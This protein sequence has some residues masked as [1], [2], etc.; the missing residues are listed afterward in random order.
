M[1][2][3]RGSWALVVLATALLCRAGVASEAGRLLVSSRDTAA[4]LGYAA[5]TGASEGAFIASG[6]GGLDETYGMLLGPD[7][8]L[9]VVGS[10]SNSVLRF[11]PET[12]AF[13]D[14]FVASGSGGL[15]GA[16]FSA[17]GPDGDLYVTSHFGHSVL[18]YDG[19]TGAFVSTFIPPGTGGLDSPGGL[20]FGPDGN[21]YLSDSY[22]NR[23]LRFDGRTGTFLDVFAAGELT[24]SSSL[25]F[26]P[27]GNLYVGSFNGNAVVRFDGRTGE[28]IDTFVT[29]GSGGLSGAVD[30]AFGPGGDLFVTSTN[31]D[32]VLRYDGTTGAF[33]SV[34]VQANSGGLDTPTGMAFLLPNGPPIARAG[35]DQE[36]TVAHDGKPDTGIAAVTLSGSASSDPDGDALAYQWEDENRE[37]VGS[38]VDLQL[39][40]PAG[41]FRYTL[42]VTDP[43]G[44]TSTD[45]VSVSVLPEPNQ[46]P[47]AKAGADQTVSPPHDGD[48]STSSVDVHLDGG[49]STDPDGDGLSYEWRDAEGEV[50]GR[51]AAI[52]LELNGGAHVLTLRVTDPYGAA[53]EDQVTVTVT[54]ELDE[55][56]TAYAGPDQ[57]VSIPHDGSPNTNL[58]EVTLA[59]DASFDLDGDPLAF[60]WEDPDGNVVGTSA[61]LPLTLPAGEYRYT[62]RVTDPYGA[63][64][65]DV[66]V[67]TVIPEANR[68][69]TASAGSDQSLT[70]PHD[71]D[72]GTRTAAVHLDGSSATDR[73]GDAITFE[74]RS[75]AG[76]VLAATAHL[77][78]TLEPGVHAFTLRVTDAYGIT[79]EDGVTVTVQPE[80][81]APPAANAG[82]DQTIRARRLPAKVRLDGNGSR[83]PDGDA[84]R[85]VW[86][87]KGHRVATGSQPRLQL[88]AG[89]HRIKLTV[90]DPYG[91]Q[92]SDT[93]LITVRR[94]R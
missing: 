66:V 60:R 70:V 25:R 41:Q 6:T 22:N 45:E 63:S 38:A 53:A 75:A 92:T 18:R 65:T 27:D 15:N 2:G 39:Q 61:T 57:Q 31:T 7:R 47:A 4:V 51:E 50:L 16:L 68:A 69:P 12:G 34:F 94:R 93:V 76:E 30:L 86:S 78:L 80:P 89:R 71:G 48:P 9:Y 42:R 84:L 11:D 72:P 40:L 44:A 82:P 24:V 74:W 14:V 79:A 1:R 56:P 10:R 52:S 23:V 3:I 90:R 32:Q 8:K 5:D 46:A 20:V 36:V 64:S 28:Y 58:A 88:P 81:N 91:A 77:D 59:G 35:S 85:Y 37:V 49:R 33:K 55:S 13:L 54:A 19:Q 73:D 21:L 67:V 26:G 87:L 62:L 29:P 17:F 43:D 83:D